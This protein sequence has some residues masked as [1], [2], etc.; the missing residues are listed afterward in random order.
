AWLGPEQREWLV[1]RL[2]AE[3]DRCVHQHGLGVI[4]ALSTGVVWQLG[5]LACLASG[6]GQYALGLWLPQIV[7]GF[8]GLSN[9]QVGFVSA[10]SYLVARPAL[11]PFAA[12]SGPPGGRVI[13]TLGGPSRAA[14]GLVV[15][16]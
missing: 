2:A 3:R 8:S 10:V 13:L 9:L 7:R 15:V 4:R 6:F 16:Y 1:S 12:P 5:L 14:C 11:V